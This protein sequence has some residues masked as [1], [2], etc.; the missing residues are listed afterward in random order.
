MGKRVYE[1]EF[2]GSQEVGFSMRHTDAYERLTNP[3]WVVNDAFH[4]LSY[5][6]F[7]TD[8][9]LGRV[10]ATRF[11]AG[12]DPSSGAP[13]VGDILQTRLQLSDEAVAY[14]LSVGERNT[15]F[16]C[17]SEIGLGLLCKTYDT[18]AGLGLYLHIHSRP[19]PAV[20]LLCAGALGTPSGAGFYLSRRIRALAEPPRRK[21]VDCFEALRDAWQA[22]QAATG[23]FFASQM[24]FGGGRDMLGCLPSH[25]TDRRTPREIAEVVER[26]AAFAGCSVECRLGTDVDTARLA[27]YR[28]FLL[29]GLLLYLLTEVHTHA[30]DDS[31]VVEVGSAEDPRSRWER[32]LT[33]SFS[34]RV[35]TLHMPIRVRNRLENTHR[36]LEDVADRAGLRLHFPRLIPPDLRALGSHKAEDYLFRQ[37]VSMEWLTDPC[38]LP[39]SDLKHPT[40]L[41]RPEDTGF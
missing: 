38:V 14:L 39:T 41:D 34:Y 28:P 19:G 29:E 20:R 11:P 22:V 1:R 9:D 23:G 8:A 33:L 2:N 40:G 17:L 25:H 21:D 15:P 6:I 4:H 5:A 24:S 10:I 7:H 31:A 32:R 12:T 26:M 37:T 27:L 18:E 13:E 35:D 3:T 16:F 36:Y 30:A